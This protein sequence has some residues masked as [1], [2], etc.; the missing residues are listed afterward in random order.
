MAIRWYLMAMETIGTYRAPKYLRSKGNPTG[1]NVQWG[2]M[3]YGLMDVCVCWADTTNAQNTALVA[4]SDCKLAATNANLD[5][6]IGSG[7][8]ATVRNVLE[9]LQIP[10]SWVQATDTW[11]QILRGTC[12]LFQ[13]AQ[14]LHGKF[15]VKLVPDGMTLSTT[16]AELPQAGQDFLTQTAD[17]LG[18]DHSGVTGSTTLRAI[19]K[20]LGDAWGTKPLYVS[21]QEL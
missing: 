21:G 20:V 2:A 13:F 7:A 3:D 19:Y 12:G 9:T 6:A 18:I 16:W 8:V 1:L 11:R 15:G 17:E 4:N 14:R 10:G 5:N